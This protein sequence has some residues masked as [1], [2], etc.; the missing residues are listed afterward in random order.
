[1][2]DR[3][4]APVYDG[5]QRADNHHNARPAIDTHAGATTAVVDGVYEGSHRGHIA[6]AQQG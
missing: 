1:V 6:W 4:L 5:L 3:V 2:L